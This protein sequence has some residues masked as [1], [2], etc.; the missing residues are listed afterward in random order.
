MT[1]FEIF[2]DQCHQASMHDLKM[3][4]LRY[5]RLRLRPWMADNVTKVLGFSESTVVSAALDCIGRNLSR[6]ATTGKISVQFLF[7]TQH[8]CFLL[9]HIINSMMHD[10]DWTTYRIIT[11]HTTHPHTLNT[12]HS[13]YCNTHTPHT[14]HTLTGKFVKQ[15]QICCVQNL[16][17]SV[18][19][20]K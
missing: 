16:N 19:N 5:I 9:D 17:C 12:H 13:H 3:Q 15:A 20:L 1:V 11:P 2:T 8:K 10:T 4:Y 14:S 6:Q 18:F 7:K